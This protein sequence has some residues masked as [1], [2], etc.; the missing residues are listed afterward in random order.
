LFSSK[1]WASQAKNSQAKP[2]AWE[3]AQASHVTWWEKDSVCFERGAT[4][5]SFAGMLTML[6]H[7]SLYKLPVANQG[8]YLLYVMITATV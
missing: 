8:K 4:M 6:S 1:I 3:A 5:S 2:S 7:S